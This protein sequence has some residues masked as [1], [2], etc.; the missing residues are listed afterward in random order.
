MIKPLKN[1][2]VVMPEKTL[3]ISAGGII[4]PDTARQKPV[5]GKVVAVGPGKVPPPFD[6]ADTVLYGK[7]SGIPLQQ[8]GTDY[9]LLHHSEVLA[10]L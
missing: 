5:R 8:G 3:A 4:I 9:L 10:V 6:I 2:L 1:R 7:A